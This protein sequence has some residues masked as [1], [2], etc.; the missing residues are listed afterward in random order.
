M[1]N[2]LIIKT[3]ITSKTDNIL[4]QLFR[5][6]FVGGTAFIVDLGLLY[7]LTEY[8]HIHYIISASLSFIAGL[9]VNY[10]ISTH[11]VFDR[12]SSIVTNKSFEF[13]LFSLI[14]II[15][16][17]L[18]DSLIWVLTEFCSL[19]YIL[20]KIVTAILVYLWNFFARKYFIFNKKTS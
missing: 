19:Y 3:L 8:L 16:L 17:A 15:G 20:S 10:I 12:K 7:L 5:Y 6:T 2:S 9:L 14:G 1:N 18:N 13:L 4:I 11:W